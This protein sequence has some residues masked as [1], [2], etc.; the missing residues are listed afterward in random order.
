MAR[1]KAT[2]PKKQRN[3]YPPESVWDELEKA[4]AEDGVKAPDMVLSF[5]VNGLAL[6]KGFVEQGKK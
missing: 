4:A 3:F 1:P 2:D 5:V 6:R